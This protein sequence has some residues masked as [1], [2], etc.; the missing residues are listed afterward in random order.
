MKR[1][2]EITVVFKL[3]ANEE[4][5]K[6]S[7]EQIKGFIEADG[8]GTVTK[9]DTTHWGR[10][11]L[12]YEIEGQR[13]AYYVIYYADVESGAIDELER[14]LRLSPQVLRHLVVRADE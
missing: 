12:A 13:E 14:E 6:E 5:M 9:I 11:R 2:Y 7:F 1:S 4:A 10:R 8:Q 3:D